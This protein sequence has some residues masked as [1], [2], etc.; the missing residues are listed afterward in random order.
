MSDKTHKRN[1]VEAT[2]VSMGFDS[3]DITMS[4]KAYENNY[5]IGSDYNIEILTQI[6]I[7]LQQKHSEN[8]HTV[9]KQPMSTSPS[10]FMIQYPPFIPH[11][12][13]DDAMRL[14][15]GDRLDYMDNGG[16]FVFTEVI[17]KREDSRTPELKIYDGRA[18]K[19]CIPTQELYRLAYPGS[20]SLRKGKKDVLE[21]ISKTILHCRL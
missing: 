19:W 21:I 20:I 13:L 12:P 11:M 17:E 9:S 7:D 18:M 16:R 10:S 1:V 15:V 8:N 6:I 4:F 14:C 2:L 3:S 5:G